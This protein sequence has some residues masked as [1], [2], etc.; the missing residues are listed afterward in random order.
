MQP[1]NNALDA[2]LEEHVSSFN[3]DQNTLHHMK[4]ALDDSGARHTADLE[5]EAKQLRQQ[6]EDHVLD[7]ATLRV[8]KR[9]RRAWKKMQQAHAASVEAQTAAALAVEVETRLEEEREGLA[10]EL[11]RLDHEKLFL[12]TMMRD[13]QRMLPRSKHFGSD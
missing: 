8:Q 6:M 10:R 1:D 13:L 3:V 11:R 12:F 2:F 9:H 5:M 4:A 7:A